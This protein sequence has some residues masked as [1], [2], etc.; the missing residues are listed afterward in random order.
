MTKDKYNQMLQFAQMLASGPCK[1]YKKDVHEDISK[2]AKAI[3][4]SDYQQSKRPRTYEEVYDDCKHIVIEYALAERLKGMRNPKE[5]DKTDADSYYWDVLVE[6]IIANILFECKRHK[7]NGGEM[8]SYSNKG[9]ETFFKHKD[10]LD[11]VV[12]AR[13]NDF[14]DYYLVNFTY[15][16]DAPSFKKYW[17]PSK[18]KP[19]WESMYNNFNSLREKACVKINLL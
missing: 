8:F 4:E 17:E 18:Y 6:F 16:M 19:L 12:T 15:I 11:Y 9:M 2:M 1:V 3:Y 14:E 10:K 7:E 13:V 5:F